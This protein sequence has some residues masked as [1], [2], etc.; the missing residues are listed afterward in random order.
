MDLGLKGKRAVVT[1]GTRGI[2]RA[3]AETLAQEGCD[4]AICARHADPVAEATA[5]LRAK[6]VK[7]IGGVVDVADGEALK[8]WIKS[9]GEALG[10]IDILVSNPSGGGGATPDERWAGNF[11]VDVM[12]AVHAVEAARP[13]LE[14]AAAASGDAAVVIISSVSAAVAWEASPYGAMKAALIHLAKGLAR[15]LA[16]KHVRANTISPGAVY[17]EGGIWH[18]MEQNKPEYFKQSM[19]MCP[20]GRMATP[21]D[22][23]RAA[24]FLASPASSYTT[25]IN[26]VV[27]GAALDRVNY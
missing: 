27:D 17:F 1:G 9:A 6:G 21:Q 20:L 19:A 24:A 7:A 15:E 2:G 16:P 13:F 4:V 25:G 3:I 26:L 12:G 8:A 11:N 14:Q 10:G 5:S 23:A 18:R 22:I